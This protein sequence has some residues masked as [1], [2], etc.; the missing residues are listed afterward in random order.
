MSERQNS[1]NQFWITLAAAWFVWTVPYFVLV[2]WR[3]NFP[4]QQETLDGPIILFFWALSLSIMAVTLT[5]RFRPEMKSTIGLV[6]AVALALIFQ[7]VVL[8]VVSL[9]LG[10][11]L[12]LL[13][14]G[15]P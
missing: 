12:F 5:R 11:Y 10:T 3:A 2:I 14:G 15:T 9:F 7:V 8:L 4:D 6:V 1:G 13:A